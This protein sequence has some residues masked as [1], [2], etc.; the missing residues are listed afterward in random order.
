[1]MTKPLSSHGCLV[2]EEKKKKNFHLYMMAHGKLLKMCSDNW[3]YLMIPFNLYSQ[4]FSFLRESD[5]DRDRLGSKK[6]KR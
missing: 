6:I 5:S 1:M 4:G 2:S 3:A